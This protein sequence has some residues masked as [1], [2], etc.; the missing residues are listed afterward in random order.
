MDSFLSFYTDTFRP[1]SGQSHQGWRDERRTRI[2]RPEW[3]QVELFDLQ[4]EEEGGAQATARFEQSYRSNRFSDRVRK[5]LRLTNRGQGWRIAEERNEPAPGPEPVAADNERSDSQAAPGPSA[6]SE[7]TEVRISGVKSEEGKTQDTALIVAAITRWADAW[8]RQDVPSYLA[9][10][11]TSF[12]PQGGQE[13]EA[14]QD[15]R[16]SR[17]L[18]PDWIDVAVAELG[19]TRISA[20]RAIANFRQ[21]YRSSTLSD[22]VRKTL[23]LA[24]EDGEWKIISESSR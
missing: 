3:I 10:Y 6:G 22:T 15:N 13:R 21:D 4:I 9:A 5:V 14:W 11:S 18:A 24:K 2:R 1:A 20:D 19:V 8:S 12:T 23:R 17:I 16:R 7:P